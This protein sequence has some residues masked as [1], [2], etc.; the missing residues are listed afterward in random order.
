V[1]SGKQD[2]LLSYDQIAGLTVDGEY[3]LCFTL[4]NKKFLLDQSMDKLEKSLPTSSFFRLNR[5]TLLHRQIISGFQRA[6]NG[7]LNILLRNSTM[8]VSTPINVSRTRAAA[9]K[10]WFQPE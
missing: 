6:E 5:Q 10:A 3:I 4:D 7:K 1:K 2:I 9:F 8:P